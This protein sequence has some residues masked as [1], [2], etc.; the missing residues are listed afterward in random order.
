MTLVASFNDRNM[1][2]MQATVVKLGQKVFLLQTQ[3]KR[4]LSNSFGAQR[5]SRVQS[6]KT[7]YARNL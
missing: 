6:Y 7:F 3:Y 2:M 1:F 4:R 5:Q